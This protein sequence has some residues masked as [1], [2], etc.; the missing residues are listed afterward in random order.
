MEA[1][2]A[3]TVIGIIIVL[4]LAVPAVANRTLLDSQIINYNMSAEI[5]RRK[6]NISVGV[7]AGKNMNFGKV[8]KQN[9]ITKFINISAKDPYHIKVDTDGNITE[10]LR[11]RDELLKKEG[12]SSSISVELIGNKVG[13]F[14][15]N[16]KLTVT[17]PKYGPGERWLSIREKLF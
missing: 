17:T 2:K 9:N 1:K 11:Y 4:L 15:G 13:N 6:Q 7:D 10:Q 12:G 14:T 5:V 3:L 16:L 8:P